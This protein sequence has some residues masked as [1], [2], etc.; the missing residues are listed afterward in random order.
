[1]LLAPAEITQ[2]T[3]G[4]FEGYPSG[5]V[6]LLSSS[7]GTTDN[8]HAIDPSDCAGVIFGAEQ[9]IYA[10][11]GYER[12]SDQTLG[13]STSDLDDLVEQTVV[14]FLTEK[15][16]NAV[17]TSLK[18]LWRRCAAGHPTQYQSGSSI[19]QD[20]G[21]EKGWGWYLSDLNI[22]DDDLT[23]MRMTAVDNLNGNAP[24]CQLA[25]GVRR[26]VLVRTR[27]C[28]DTKANPNRP[29]PSAAG[30]YASQLAQDMLERVP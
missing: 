5:P 19:D 6:E 28:V 1:M 16:A 12:I 24:A 29:A 10:G 3:G 14:V 30:Y 21:Y 11:T 23:T 17:L 4:E 13:K 8:T 7:Q 27:T 9:Q 18:T 26:N 2:T 22:G 15:Q 20:A 25:V